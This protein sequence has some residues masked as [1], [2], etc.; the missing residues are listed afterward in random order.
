VTLLPGGH[1][2]LGHDKGV[3]VA[4]ELHHCEA[5]SARAKGEKKEGQRGGVQGAELSGELS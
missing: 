2:V 5:K 4:L 1:T 3:G